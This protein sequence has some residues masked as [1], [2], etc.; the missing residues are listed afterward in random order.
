MIN[1]TLEHR[2]RSQLIDRYNQLIHEGESTIDTFPLEVNI[3][4]RDNLIAYLS[5]KKKNTQGFR[6]DLLDSGFSSLEHSKSHILYSM[7]K[8]LTHLGVK[9]LKPTPLT[10]ITPQESRSLINKRSENLF[11]KKNEQLQST[12][13]VTLDSENA[14]QEEAVKDLLINGMNIARINCAH[15]HKEIWKKMIITLRQAEKSLQEQGNYSNQRCKVF[16]D[17][18]GPK[19]RVGKLLHEYQP[20]KIFVDSYRKTV[21]KTNIYLDSQAEQT[22]KY[23]NKLEQSYV[24]AVKDQSILEQLRVADELIFTDSKKRERKMKVVEVISPT[25]VKVELN[26]TAYVDEGTILLYG[27]LKIEVHSFIPEPVEIFVIKGDILRLYLDPEK[28]GHPASLNEPAGVPVSIAKAFKNVRISDRIFIDDGKIAGRVKEVNKEFIDIEILSPIV[29]KA[30]VREDKGLNLPDS[31]LSLNLPAITNQDLLDLPFILNNADILGLSFVHS[32]LDLVKL[33]YE[34]GRYSSHNIAV[35]AKI[36][37]KDSIHHLARI[38][39]E[40]LKFKAFGIMIAR[41]D[42]TVEVGPENLAFVQNEILAICSAAHVPVILA[43]GVLERLTKK[44]VPTRSE[45]TDA[46]YGKIA[47]CV[48]LNKGKFINDSLKMLSILLKKEENHS[49]IKHLPP[50]TYVEQYRIF[51][52]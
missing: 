25:C 18:A 51:S 7:K 12:I 46:A 41:G 38:I 43:T 45:L 15:D 37:T 22:I 39:L 8:I 33:R 17:M 47:D 2:V 13:M 1:E 50:Q 6:Q 52:Q 24:L 9:K 35:I 44:G 28:L 48:M 14:T 27:N 30:K 26:K 4:S 36:E 40:G 32:P 5:I 3:Q 11:G 31:L 21:H 23:K 29:E 20:L 19:I 42:L 49:D 16:M 10:A 34:L